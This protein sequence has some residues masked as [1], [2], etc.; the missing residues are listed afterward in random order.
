MEGPGI[1]NESSVVSE[2]KQ[3]FMM[4]SAHRVLRISELYDA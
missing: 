3:P 4:D 2:K 1:V